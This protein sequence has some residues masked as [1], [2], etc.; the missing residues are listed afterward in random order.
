[1]RL[2]SCV[3]VLSM[4][5]ALVYA[6]VQVHN[7]WVRASIGS[8]TMTAAYMEL[9]S[10]QGDDLL[11]A[12]SDSAQEVQIHSMTTENGIMKMRQQPHLPI[13]KGQTVQ[14]KPGGYH[15]MLLGLKKP[16]S[17]GEVISLRLQFASQ[18]VVLQVPVQ[19]ISY[20]QEHAMPSHKH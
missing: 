15:L 18:T 1:M 2:K 16:L 14:L 8:Q 6:D 17:S 12:S 5:P 4:I 3:L 19:P 9:T 7:P 20:S 11:S 13:H 10:Q